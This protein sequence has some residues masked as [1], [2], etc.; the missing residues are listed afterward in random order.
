[1]QNLGATHPGGC[2]IFFNGTI[3]TKGMEQ[4]VALSTQAVTNGFNRLT[5]CM[6]SSGGNPDAAL[7][8]YNAL[9]RLRTY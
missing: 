7:Y 4:L 6:S 8:G 2:F 9:S 3:D 5:I 1:M